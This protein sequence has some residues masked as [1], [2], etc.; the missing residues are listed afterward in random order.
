M[1]TPKVFIDSNVWFSAFYGS[2]NCEK[3]TEAHTENKIKAVISQ[4]VLQEIVKNFTQKMPNAL[5]PFIKTVSVI[6]SK[7]IR[8]PTKIPQHV[9]SLAHPKDQ[10]I[11][12]SAILAKVNCF[13]TDNTKHFKT[14]EI[15]KKTGIKIVTPKQ[16]VKILNL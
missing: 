16:A 1:K 5:D 6:P 7:I 8:D 3:I 11:L 14:N 4:K 9:K 10:N 2:A 15:K 12:A 13:V